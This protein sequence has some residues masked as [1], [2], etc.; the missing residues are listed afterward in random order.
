[1]QK[2]NA[3]IT[4]NAGLRTICKLMLN[5]FYGKY[6]DYQQEQRENLHHF[7]YVDTDSIHLI[8]LIPKGIEVDDND[9]GKWKDGGFL[10][11]ENDII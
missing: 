8:A 11:A 3:T 2:I 6:R 4:G 9:L 10:Y 7:L 1:M 5:S